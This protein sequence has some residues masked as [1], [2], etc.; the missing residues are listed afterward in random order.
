MSDR[1]DSAEILDDDAEMRCAAAGSGSR[2]LVESNLIGV[3]GDPAA[4][5]RAAYL[6]QRTSLADGLGSN[7]P[8]T[9]HDIYETQIA[10]MHG[11]RV[12][13]AERGRV[14]M[15]WEIDERYGQGTYWY[16]PL[17]D[18]LSVAI[19]DLQFNREVGFTCQ[20]P[21]LFCFGSYGRNMVPYFGITD[22]PADRTLLGYAWKSQPYGQVTKADERLDVTSICML[23]K[24]LQ[25]LSLACH[26]DPL[27]LSRAIASLDGMQ[28]VPGLNMV[29]DEMKRARPSSITA[30]AYY[31]AKVTEAAAMLLDWSLA[32]ARGAASA[33]R[34]ADRSALNLTRAHIREHL[35]RAVPSSE[36]CQTGDF[37]AHRLANPC[38]EASP[39]QPKERGWARTARQKERGRAEAR[40]PHVQ[41]QAVS[42]P[43]RRPSRSCPSCPARERRCRSASRRPRPR[44]GAAGSLR[45]RRPRPDT[46]WRGC[47]RS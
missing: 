35:D 23:P 24:G 8:F 12:E 18:D 27:V 42:P 16:Y 40:P 45:S 26:C 33:I 34:A 47:P 30:P 39:R 38:S 17:G 19:F 20:T 11:V 28:D 31:E 4:R 6:A 36:L 10:S 46:G 3:G 7:G 22:D 43:R 29:F 44:S 15:L 2:A 14:G 25:R 5:S 37:A 9:V 41:R 13:A 32:N 21:D 1:D